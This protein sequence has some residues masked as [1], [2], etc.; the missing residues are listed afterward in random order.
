MPIQKLLHRSEFED[1]LQHGKYLFHVH[2]NYT[3]GV[4]KVDEYCSLCSQKGFDSL[5]IIEH[6]REKLGYSFED[7]NNEVLDARIKNP[8]LKVSLGVETKVMPNGNLDIDS[9]LLE[10]TE[11]LGIACHGFPGN[12]EDL[13]KSMVN[14]FNRYSKNHSLCVWLHPSSVLKHFDELEGPRK[15]RNLIE[16]A[17]SNGIFVEWNIS[18]DH[19]S[20]IL[21]N[22]IPDANLVFGTN[23]HSIEELN[24][25]I[26][27]IQANNLFKTV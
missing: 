23:A 16:V 14:T 1:I 6:V 25:H 7:L 4:S 21:P 9:K 22:W 26:K 20:S 17:V 5:F 24:A 3:D 8:E 11:I 10:K 15:V 12:P 19:E 27:T 18:R 13:Y 2:T